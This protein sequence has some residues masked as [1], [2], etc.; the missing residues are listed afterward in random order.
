[1]IDYELG[2]KPIFDLWWYRRQQRWRNVIRGSSSKYVPLETGDPGAHLVAVKSQRIGYSSLYVLWTFSSCRPRWQTP[3][4]ISATDLCRSNL[5]V[6]SHVIWY[7]LHETP[8]ITHS[9]PR[10]E[11][12]N[13]CMPRSETRHLGARR[14]VAI[15]QTLKKNRTS[16]RTSSMSAKNSYQATYSLGDGGMESLIFISDTTTE[17]VFYVKQ[18]LRCCRSISSLIVKEQL[19]PANSFWRNW[20]LCFVPTRCQS[21]TN[22]TILQVP[23]WLESRQCSGHCEVNSANAIVRR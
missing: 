4:I 19:I 6:H 23:M 18:S 22:C 5:S 1:M 21:Q 10:H 12:F 20:Q 2:D 16:I 14:N 9:E 7:N 8:S 11:Q 3:T 17:T 13:E 15:N